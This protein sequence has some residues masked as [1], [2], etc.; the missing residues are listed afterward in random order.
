[1]TS[2]DWPVVE[3]LF[4]ANGACGGCWCMWWRTPGGKA[5][6][7]AKGERNRTELKCLVETERLHAVVAFAGSDPVGW[8]CFGEQGDFPRLE[9]VKALRDVRDRSAWSIVCLFIKARWRRQ[10][11]A[12]R[13]VDAAATHAF[14]LGAPKVEGYP[15]PPKP[16]GEAIPAAFA[17]TGVPRIFEDAEFERQAGD[18]AKHPV[19][20]KLRPS[21]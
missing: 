13:L 8:C 10:G 20:V 15:V 12:T 21:S 19:Y 7:A 3:T 6:A 14:A 2:D 11:V 1:V 5:W 16:T 9:T 17:F 18:D 4:G